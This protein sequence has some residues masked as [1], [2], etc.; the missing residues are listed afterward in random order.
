MALFTAA[1]QNPAPQLSAPQIIAVPVD[2]MVHPITVEIIGH[3]IEQAQAAHATRAVD[4][5][6]YSGRLA[7]GHTSDYPATFSVADPG[8][9]IC[10]TE[11]S[12]RRLGGLLSASGRRCC[13]H[14]AGNEYGSGVPGSDGQQMDPVMREKVEND[15]A[16]LLRSMTSRRGRNTQLAE[17]AVRKAKAFTEKEALDQKLIDLIASDEQQLLKSWMGARLRGGMARKEVLHVAGA[18][19]TEVRRTLRERLI[20]S[21]ADPN[22]GF[23]LLVLGALGIYVEFS[24]PGLIF[25]GVAGAILVLLGALG[26]DY[27]ADQLGR[28]RAAGALGD[29]VCFGGKVRLAWEF[30]GLARRSQWC[31]VQCC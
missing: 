22:I 23:I 20:G 5:S 8:D 30:W 4:P 26:A 12:T 24:S 19:V 15:A 2:G 7:R 28:R 10:D 9:H 11:W 14:V 25:A 21:I 3:A 1:G 17:D 13:G 16:A 6:E 27:P 31:W 18:T 29:A